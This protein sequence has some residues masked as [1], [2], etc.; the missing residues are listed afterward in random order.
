M[1]PTIVTTVIEA[2]AA[3][4]GSDPTEL[5]LALGEYVNPDALRRLTEHE[6]DSWWL[7][8]G[9]ADHRVVVAGDGT[10]HIDDEVIRRPP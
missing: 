4:E 9:T 2:V 3:A 8:F 7:A 5:D 6:N 1:D 10:V